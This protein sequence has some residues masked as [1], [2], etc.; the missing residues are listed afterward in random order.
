M[1]ALIEMPRP[2]KLERLTRILRV[3][4]VDV[5][6]HWSVLAIAAVMIVGG[7]RKPLLAV[8]VL[9]SWI[10]VLLLHECGHM[11][12]AH[13]KRCEV[14]NIQLYPIF[15]L[16]EFETPWSRIDRA[17]IAWGGVVAQAVVGIPLVTWILVFGY[18]P[19]E[20]LNAALALFG[21]FSLVEATFNL[22]PKPPLDGAV[23]WDLIPAL[24]N[25][26][27]DRRNKRPPA[28]RR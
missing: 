27:R 18:T 12:M 15:G 23:A 13:R 20:P 26:A 21:F 5:Y 4:G 3:R 1:P 7:I 2:V 6:V 14:L 16:C 8:T 25:R 9:I 24:I 17:K 22:I 28:W 11:I 10:G 19:F